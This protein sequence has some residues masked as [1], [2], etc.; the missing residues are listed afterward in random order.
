MQLYNHDPGN[1]KVNTTA[2]TVILA[3]RLCMHFWQGEPVYITPV[4][5][6]IKHTADRAIL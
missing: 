3:K 4:N 2:D 1:K 6:A 5:N